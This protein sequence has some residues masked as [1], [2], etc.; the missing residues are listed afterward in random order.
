MN[1]ADEQRISDLDK[2][3]VGGPAVDRA[4]HHATFLRSLGVVS[5]DCV[6][7]AASGRA[8]VLRVLGEGYRMLH[9]ISTSNQN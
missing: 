5:V 8:A 1:S 7:T 2:A 6:N 4:P 3:G 9:S